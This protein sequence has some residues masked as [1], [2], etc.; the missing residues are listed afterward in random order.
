M[1]RNFQ[2]HYSAIS[3]FCYFIN[4]ALI[5]RPSVSKPTVSTL[6]CILQGA[7]SLAGQ[8]EVGIRSRDIG[9]LGR[10]DSSRWILQNNS[11]EPACVGQGMLALV[12]WAKQEWTLPDKM[13]GNSSSLQL[14]AV[15]KGFLANAVPCCEC[16]HITRPGWGMRGK[17]GCQEQA[18]T[19]TA[20]YLA[21]SLLLALCKT[22]PGQE[23]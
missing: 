13:Y 8:S 19:T 2:K 12:L 17:G 23:S 4:I 10:F 9:S 15:L 20:N 3:F 18:P 16:G 7:E 5:L 6:V 14:P 1:L 22:C 11:G 21:C